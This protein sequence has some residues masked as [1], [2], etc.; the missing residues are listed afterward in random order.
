MTATQKKAKAERKEQA[1]QKLLAAGA[2]N[3]KKEDRFGDT[4]TGWWIDDVCLGKD[5]VE[6]VRVME[7][8]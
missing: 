6:A 3:L 7:G 5:P 2:E 8:N 1:I 4:K